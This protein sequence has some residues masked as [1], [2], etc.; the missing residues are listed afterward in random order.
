MDILQ[1]QEID[2]SDYFSEKKEDPRKFYKYRYKIDSEVNQVFKWSPW[3]KM[4]LHEF[5]AEM[6]RK[7]IKVGVFDT[8]SKVMSSLSDGDD[9]E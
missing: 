3:T 7:G 4:K 8:H 1:V 2:G 5:V 9:R 6:Q